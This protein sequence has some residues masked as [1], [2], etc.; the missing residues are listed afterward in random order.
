[1]EGRMRREER[2]GSFPAPAFGC[3]HVRGFE[4]RGE[5]RRLSLHFPPEDLSRIGGAGRRRFV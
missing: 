3:G 2:T 4:G 1:M 5:W